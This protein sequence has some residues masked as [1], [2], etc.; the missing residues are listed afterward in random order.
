MVF[1]DGMTRRIPAGWK[2]QFPAVVIE[3]GTAVVRRADGG[4]MTECFYG[5]MS[6]LLVEASLFLTTVPGSVK[7]PR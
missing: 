5:K 2:N 1:P 4:A 6:S 3:A 7:T